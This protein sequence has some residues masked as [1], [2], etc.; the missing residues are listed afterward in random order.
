M[1]ADLAL[2][3]PTSGDGLE[4]MNIADS[5][6]EALFRNRG[7]NITWSLDAWDDAAAESPVTLA[8]GGFDAE[9]SFPVF[10]EGAFLFLDGGT[11]DLGVQRDMT[12]VTA[13]EYATFVETFENVAKVGCSALWATVPVC[14]SGAAAALADT[15]C[16]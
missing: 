1:A 4:A 12:M 5:K 2:Q 6:I 7:Y 3:M 8:N 10:P 9:V 14:V 15:S 13:N 11:L 16:A